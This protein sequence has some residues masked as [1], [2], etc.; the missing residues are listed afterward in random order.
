MKRAATL[1]FAFAFAAVLS[2]PAFAETRT[3][4]AAKVS[5]EIPAGYKVEAGEN[6]MTITDPAGELGVFFLILE[7]DDLQKALKAVDKEVGKV[8][9]GVKW[10]DEPSEVKLNGM[11]AVGLDGKGTVDGVA[12]ELGVMLVN[13]PADKILLV[14]GAVESDKAKKHEA[15]VEGMLKS[16]KP[17]K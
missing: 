13:T 16:I 10:D 7:S 1:F 17:A 4:A 2:A 5:I 8:A 14:L 3:H 9:K 11:D 15:A 6:N 12:A